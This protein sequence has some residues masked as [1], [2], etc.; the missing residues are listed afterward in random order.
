MHFF[1]IFIS[2]T[3]RWA[4]WTFKLHFRSLTTFEMWKPIK[5]LPP[6]SWHH[7][8]CLCKHFESFRS[9]VLTVKQNLMH[10]LF[11]KVWPLQSPTMIAEPIQHKQTNVNCT[12][13][14]CP[15]TATP[16]TLTHNKSAQRYVVAQSCI[17]SGSRSMRPSRIL[18]ASHLVPASVRNRSTSV[19]V[20]RPVWT[21]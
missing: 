2:P 5:S 9:W 17:I 3:L 18:L 4:T 16:T 11:M 21:H 10:I 19:N 15:I 6:Y 20:K 7:H 14:Q 1:R 12:C 8:E 13:T